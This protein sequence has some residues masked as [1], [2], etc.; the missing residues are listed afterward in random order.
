MTD[1]LQTDATYHKTHFRPEL[2]DELYAFLQTLKDWRTVTA[3]N[4]LLVNYFTYLIFK[5]SDGK[6]VAIIS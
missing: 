1:V 4:G 3:P 2:V 5:I 6:F